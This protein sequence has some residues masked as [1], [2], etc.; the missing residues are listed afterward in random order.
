[1]LASLQEGFGRAYLEAMMHGLPVIAH[2]HPV[3]EYVIGNEERLED[4]SKPGALAA[5]LT[6]VLDKIQSEA[7]MR[8]RWAGVRD[9]FGW[10]ALRPHYLEMFRRCAAFGN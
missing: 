4:L 10:D 5:A 8:H 9:R 3:M 7:A 6:D 1:V 2:R